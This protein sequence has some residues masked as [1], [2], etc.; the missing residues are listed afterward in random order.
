MAE[1]RHRRIADDLTRRIRAGHWS[2]GE[3]PPSR[4]DLAAHYHVHE[5]TIRLAVVLLR[6]RGIVEGEQR[7]RL[8]VAHPP[9]MRA[10]TDPDADWPYGSEVTDT[11]P[12][13]ATVELAERL[14]VPVGATL[15]YEAVECMDPGGRS[16]MLVSAGRGDSVDFDRS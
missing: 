6:K 15:Q 3:Q 13:R 2:A 11:R 4:A 8:Y 5:Q 10:L 16:A 14:G 12:R 7:K 9:A 1:A